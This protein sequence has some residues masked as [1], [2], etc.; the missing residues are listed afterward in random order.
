MLEHIHVTVHRFLEHIHVT[1]HR[2]LEHRHV[3]FHHLFEGADLHVSS[4]LC[5]DV[6]WPPARKSNG[7]T[8]KQGYAKACHLL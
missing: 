5:F 3:T 4:R 1:F 6:F 2:F 8:Q 7:N